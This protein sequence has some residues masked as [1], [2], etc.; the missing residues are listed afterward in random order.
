MSLP[1]WGKETI[2]LGV[3]SSAQGPSKAGEEAK[4][5]IYNQDTEMLRKACTLPAWQAPN[6]VELL[7]V[8]FSDAICSFLI[9]C[10]IIEMV[11]LCRSFLYNDLAY[12]MISSNL[13]MQKN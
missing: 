5:A 1:R 11:F 3:E 7:M 13:C 9:Q 12:S 2:G 10:Q 6:T 4:K 8:L